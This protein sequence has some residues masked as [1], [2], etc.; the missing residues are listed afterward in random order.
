MAIG[1]GRL[2][3]RWFDSTGR[4]LF[5]FWQICCFGLRSA[6]RLGILVEPE[7]RMWGTHP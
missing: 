6:V 1:C 3:G 7:K 4:F 2:G 5:C